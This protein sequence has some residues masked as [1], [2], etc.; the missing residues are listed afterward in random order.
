MTS[1]ERFRTTLSRREP[2]RIPMCE[3]C[4]W[5]ETVQ[6]WRSEG[7]PEDQE[8][9]PFLGLETISMVG[10]DFSLRLPGEFREG[11]ED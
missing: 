6:R 1:R 9:G 7:L 2:D 11:T 3:I 10:G 8:P 4:F 5:P